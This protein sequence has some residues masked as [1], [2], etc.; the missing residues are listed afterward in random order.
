MLTKKNGEISI[1]SD[2]PGPLTR[3]PIIGYYDGYNKGGKSLH[4]LTSRI[5]CGAFMNPV[6]N[7]SFPFFF[8]LIESRPI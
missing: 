6:G 5:L 3:I 8:S 4:K 2:Y 1:P 7:M